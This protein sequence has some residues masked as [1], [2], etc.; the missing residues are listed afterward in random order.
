MEDDPD[1]TIDCQ[2]FIILQSQSIPI[3]IQ[4]PIITQY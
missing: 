3:M 2:V 1:V 4:H